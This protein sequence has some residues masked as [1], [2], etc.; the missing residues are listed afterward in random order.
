MSNVNHPTHYTSSPAKCAQCGA[1]IECIQITET[2]DF[3]LG[4]TIKYVWRSGLKGEAL[5]DLEKARWY[6]DRAIT[7]ARLER[8]TT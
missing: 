8:T 2:M 7:Q 1:G 6:L 3:C 5:E 4:N